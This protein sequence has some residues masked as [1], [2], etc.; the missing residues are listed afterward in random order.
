MEMSYTTTYTTETLI[1]MFLD[2]TDNE[3]YSKGRLC[4]VETERGTVQL[5]AYGNEILAEVDG[6]DVILYTGH[7]G[8][9]SQTVTDY[10]KKVGSLLNE[11][12]NRNVISREGDAPTLGI[13]ARA[14][15]ASQYIDSFVGRLT[16]G[17]FSPVE[18]DAKADV[19]EALQER[20]EA[21]FG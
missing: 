8:T 1:E 12:E 11:T 16:E 14:T 4:T 13:G 20:M 18:Q 19:E 17:D 10:L 7:Y 21:I 9:V 5:V 6:K 3:V 2:E 15:G